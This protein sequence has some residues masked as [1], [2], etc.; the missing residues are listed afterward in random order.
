VEALPGFQHEA[1]GAV[2]AEPLFFFLFEDPEGLAAE[3]V[4]G[5]P[6]TARMSRLFDPVLR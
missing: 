3:V 6:V 5:S 1:A 2:F 4:G